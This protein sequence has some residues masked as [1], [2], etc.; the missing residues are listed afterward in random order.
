MTKSW[1]M[2]QESYFE[3]E[4]V[5]HITALSIKQGGIVLC[6][7]DVKFL[8]THIQKHCTHRHTHTHPIIVKYFPEE[9]NKYFSPEK[10]KK[11]Y[12]LA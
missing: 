5:H 9:R 4:K 11:K 3:Q 2:L 1:K 6:I 8:H 10:R 12:V 7:K